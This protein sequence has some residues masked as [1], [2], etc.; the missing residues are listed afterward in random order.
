VS[1]TY[2]RDELETDGGIDGNVTTDTEA[3]KGGDDQ[4]GVVGVASSEA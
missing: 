1:K 3:D 4:K 2:L